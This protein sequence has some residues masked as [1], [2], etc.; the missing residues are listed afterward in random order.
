MSRKRNKDTALRFLGQQLA[1][2]LRADV[3][4]AIDPNG[5]ERIVFKTQR[6]C[7]G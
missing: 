6:E 3:D 2:H 1:K 5:L 4:S 7:L